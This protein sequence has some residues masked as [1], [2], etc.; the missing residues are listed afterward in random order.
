MAGPI[1]QLKQTRWWDSAVKKYASHLIAAKNQ[2]CPELREDFA[3]FAAEI[4]NT[5]E[6]LRDELLK[7]DAPTVEP[8]RRRY[9]QYDAP[10]PREQIIGVTTRPPKRRKQCGSTS[11]TPKRSRTRKNASAAPISS[12][13]KLRQASKRRSTRDSKS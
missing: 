3:R 2:K 5:P 7:I 6:R 9:R 1:E 8:A 13:P 11:Q 12:S 4:L 10:A